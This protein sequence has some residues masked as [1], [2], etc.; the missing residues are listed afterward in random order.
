MSPPPG[1]GI[2]VWSGRE[3]GEEDRISRVEKGRI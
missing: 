3:R 2:G 1:D